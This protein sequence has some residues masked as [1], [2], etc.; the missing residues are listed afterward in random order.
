MFSSRKVRTVLVSGAAVVAALTLTA[1]QSTA[2]TG[3]IPVSGRYV[4][5]AVGG[6]ECLS[7]VDLCIAGDYRGDISGSFAGSATAL[8]ATADTAS[9]TVSAFTSNSTITGAVKRY[10][11][12]LLVKNAGVFTSTP[13]GSI[14]DL[15]TI[16]G[17]TGR[18]A[19]ATGFIRASGTFSFTDGGTSVYEGSVCLP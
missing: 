11:G 18:L 1:G 6:P 13:D 12:A 15:Q 3:C 2:A 5:H 10:R 8:I 4:E 17:G 9:T 19:G 14:V 7:P 16:V